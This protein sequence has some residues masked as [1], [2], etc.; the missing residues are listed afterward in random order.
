MPKR[1]LNLATKQDFQIV[2]CFFS[3]LLVLMLA[4]GCENSPSSPTPLSTPTPT[5][6]PT[7]TV[8]FSTDLISNGYP[9]VH[10][11]A[12]YLF[13]Y[14][15]PC[16]CMPSTMASPC[17]LGLN[18]Y[19]GGYSPSIYSTAVSL[20]NMGQSVQIQLQSMPATLGQTLTWITNFDVPSVDQS[21]ASSHG[22]ASNIYTDTATFPAPLF[23]RLDATA[24]YQFAGN[25]TAYAFA[26]A[27]TDSA[28]IS[29][30]AD[31]Q[32]PQT[33]VLNIPIT[34]Q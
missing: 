3:F 6:V 10:A 28:P 17:T 21:Q 25:N 9:N 20:V 33:I 32:T 13:S 18:G 34:I 26:W 19:I 2:F 4:I 15:T 8:S 29:T 22:L 5:P 23:W 1:R 16:L 27:R 12:E 30:L 24:L 11:E 7:I 14:F 31:L